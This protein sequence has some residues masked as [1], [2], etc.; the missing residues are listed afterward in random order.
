MAEFHMFLWGCF[1]VA[2]LP[3]AVRGPMNKDS[4]TYMHG[5]GLVEWL[6]FGRFGKTSVVLWVSVSAFYEVEQKWSLG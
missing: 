1:A 5:C 4:S 6:C 3:G 2:P